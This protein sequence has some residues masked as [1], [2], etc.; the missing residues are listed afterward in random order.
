MVSFFSAGGNSSSSLVS[1]KGWGY[2]RA[3]SIFK[4]CRGAGKRTEEQKKEGSEE[5]RLVS[6]GLFCKGA[7]KIFRFISQFVW[8]MDF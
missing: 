1:K 3:A 6:K 2:N 7:L 5:G 8:D 4:M